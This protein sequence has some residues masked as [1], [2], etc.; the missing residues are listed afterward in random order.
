MST[1]LWWRAAALE[2]VKALLL[3]NLAADAKKLVRLQ[4]RIALMLQPAITLILSSPVLQVF[5]LPRP[6]SRDL[7]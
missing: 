2:A 7:P 4:R 6:A 3:A 5:A 1:E